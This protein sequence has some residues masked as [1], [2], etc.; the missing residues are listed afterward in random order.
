MPSTTASRLRRPAGAGL[1]PAN[2]RATGN[3]SVRGPEAL[4][5]AIPPLPGHS[6]LWRKH[7]RKLETL[8]AGLADHGDVNRL[9]YGGYARFDTMAAYFS[10]NHYRPIGRG[11][12]PE[13]HRGFA[14]I[15]GVADEHLY[16]YALEQWT[17]TPRARRFAAARRLPGWLG[18]EIS[19]RRYRG[20]IVSGVARRDAHPAG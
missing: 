10:G 3:R 15:W 17:A 9:M 4:S 16:D 13:R 18:D 2:L 14:N 1:L 11:E 20:F 6:I 7:N 5:L 12:L 19:M 8:G